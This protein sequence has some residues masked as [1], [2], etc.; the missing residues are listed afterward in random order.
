MTSK[1]AQAFVSRKIRK[2]RD[3]GV[4]QKQAEAEALSIARQKGY[5]IPPPSHVRKAERDP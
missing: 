5:K 1:K 4:P 3:E 2:L